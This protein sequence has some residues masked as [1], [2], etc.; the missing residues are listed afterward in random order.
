MIIARI[1]KGYKIETETATFEV[2]D[3][4]SIRGVQKYTVKDVKTGARN[5]IRRDDLLQA[6]KEG[7]A[8]VYL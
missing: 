4:F 7:S 8:R 3:S 1:Y 6:Q 2:V 5:T